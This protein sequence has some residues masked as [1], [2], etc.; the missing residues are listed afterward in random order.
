[1]KIFMR[2]QWSLWG[3]LILF[4]AAASATDGE[5]L[6]AGFGRVDITPPVGGVITGPGAPVSTGTDDP[7][8]ASALVVALAAAGGG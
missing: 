1:M 7:L 3:T 6:Q 4:T 2:G 8:R 5:S